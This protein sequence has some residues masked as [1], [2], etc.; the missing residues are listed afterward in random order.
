MF[1][2]R[3]KGRVPEVWKTRKENVVREMW[4]SVCRRVGFTMDESFRKRPEI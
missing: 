3:K 2:G 1:R 4:G